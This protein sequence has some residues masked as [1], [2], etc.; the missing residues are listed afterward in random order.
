M[1][2]RKSCLET[3]RQAECPNP[4]SDFPDTK[5]HTTLSG[6]HAAGPEGIVQQLEVRLLEEALRRTLGVGGVG[7]DDIK[8]VLVVVQELEAVTDVDLGLGVLEALSHAGEVLLREADDS[9]DSVLAFFT[10][11]HQMQQTHLINIAENSLFDTLVLHDLTQDTAI[12]TAN[13]ED[14]L[15]LGVRVH[16][17]V[18]D[19]L[20]VGELIPLSALDDVVQDQDSAVVRGLED[21]NVLVLALL[22]VQDLLDSEGHGLAYNDSH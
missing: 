5:R 14:L 12:A 6:D 19:H 16:G 17:Q 7:D 11:D 8:G 20:L 9:L 22:M 18:R 3:T 4:D 1:S 15:G 10:P 2:Q 21:E 13:D